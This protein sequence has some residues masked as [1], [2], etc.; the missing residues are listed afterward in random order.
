MMVEEL[1]C[2][3]IQ[4][5][6]EERIEPFSCVCFC[7]YEVISL[8]CSFFKLL[9]MEI[10]LTF[11]IFLTFDMISCEYDVNSSKWKYN[12]N[13]NTEAWLSRH[14]RR[15]SK[16]S[17][18]FESHPQAACALYWWWTASYGLE[19]MQLLLW[20]SICTTAFLGPT[21]INVRD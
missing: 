21:W 19:L 13:R 16:F 18:L 15:R 3:V 9:L 14:S 8:I 2:Y 11:L 4:M 10:I 5:F 20:R 12:R 6:W 1:L 7:L 17:Y